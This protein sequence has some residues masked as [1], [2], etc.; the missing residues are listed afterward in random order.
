MLLKVEDRVARTEMLLDAMLS[1]EGMTI[2]ELHAGAIKAG[3]CPPVTISEF[4]KL[5]DIHQVVGRLRANGVVD[6]DH[7]GRI[8]K[9]SLPEAVRAFLGKPAKPEPAVE[10]AAVEPAPIE[11]APAPAPVVEPAPIAPE[12]DTI[13]PII[14]PPAPTPAPTRR[15]RR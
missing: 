4:Y 10:P 12:P 14:P 8:I 2:T 3:L 13:A 9:K 5:F 7:T 6:L 11:V 15:G 1:T